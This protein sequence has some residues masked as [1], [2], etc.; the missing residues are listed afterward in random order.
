M[1]VKRGFEDTSTPGGFCKDQV[2]LKGAVEILKNRDKIQIEQLF[3]GK[4]SIQDLM[5]IE[6]K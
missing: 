2:Y 5:D 4:I 6:N 1:R 3:Y